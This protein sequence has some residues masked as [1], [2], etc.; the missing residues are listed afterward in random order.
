MSDPTDADAAPQPPAPEKKPE[1]NAAPPA[2]SDPQASNQGSEPSPATPSAAETAPPKAPTKSAVVFAK[3]GSRIRGLAPEKIEPYNF[4]STGLLT[5][6]DLRQLGVIHQRYAQH[7]AARLSTFF[8]T[9]CV[10]KISNF[11]SITFAKLCESMGNP[12]HL[13]LFQVEALSG[14]GVVEVGIKLGLAMADRLLGGKGRAP[15]EDRPL[16]EIELTLVDDVLHIILTEWSQLWGEQD[17]KFRPQVIGQETSGRFL[18]TSP[19]DAIFVAMTVDVKVGEIEGR[20]QLGVPFLMLEP[21]IKTLHVKTQTSEEARPKA[22]QWRAPYAGISVPLHAEWGIKE[23]QLREVLDIR[24]GDWF[25]LSKEI[26][27]KTRIKLSESEDYYGTAG[28]Q[29]G[30]IAVE[31]SERVHKE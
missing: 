6:V 26:I 12:T 13:T 19:P 25:E 3:D 28:I 23:M 1:E 15:A 21:V 17:E 18:Q 4:R 29:N 24:E 16:T 27:S 22:R 30:H 14:V 7:L 2:A 31:L 5:S 10:L 9:E 8:R 20:L 11:T